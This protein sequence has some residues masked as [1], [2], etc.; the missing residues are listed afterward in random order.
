MKENKIEFTISNFDFF[1][2]LSGHITANICF[3]L[4]NFLLNKFNEFDKNYNFYL[5][6]TDTEY[7]DSTF[8]GL[9]IGIEKKI[10]LIFGKHL[11]IINPSETSFK[12]LKNMGLTKILCF[13]KKEVPK[14]LLFIKINIEST[15]DEVE[16][17]KL[18]LSTHKDL[19]NLEENK[20]KFESL[21]EILGEKNKDDKKNF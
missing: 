20:D 12:L 5:D 11:I 9:I 14:D 19:S 6:L 15:I 8:I 17:K 7:M 13:E 2:K 4:K 21:K 3:N 1:L 16:M 10:N 18:V